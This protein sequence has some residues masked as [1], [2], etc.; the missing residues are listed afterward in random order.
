VSSCTYL[1][2]P[3]I[4]CDMIDALKLRF[5]GERVYLPLRGISPAYEENEIFYRL[6]IDRLSD[7]DYQ[8]E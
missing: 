8:E 4:F 5:N 7:V 3:G 2:E 6:I 1:E